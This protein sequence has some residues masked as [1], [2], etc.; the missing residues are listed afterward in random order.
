VK[1][2]AERPIRKE[3]MQ[4]TEENPESIVINILVG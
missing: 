2:N 1:T 4:K 3:R